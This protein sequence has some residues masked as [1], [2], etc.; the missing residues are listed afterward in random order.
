MQIVKKGTLLPH[1]PAPAEHP[2]HPGPHPPS[3]PP[4]SSAAVKRPAA[5]A[6]TPPPGGEGAMLSPASPTGVTPRNF[7]SASGGG[8]GPGGVPQHLPLLPGMQLPLPQSGLPPIRATPASPGATPGEYV[9]RNN[10]A[11]GEE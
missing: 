1:P 5:L 8:D 4:P 7:D 9:V 6:G 2:A 10:D 3:L 11:F